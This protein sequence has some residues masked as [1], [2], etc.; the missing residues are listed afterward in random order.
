MHCMS[1]D[2]PPCHRLYHSVSS[3]SCSATRWGRV[4]SLWPLSMPTMTVSQW[5]ERWSL[6][7]TRWSKVGVLLFYW[8]LLTTKSVGYLKVS[9]FF[10]SLCKITNYGVKWT[11]YFSCFSLCSCL[12]LSVSDFITTLLPRMTNMDRIWIGLRIHPNNMEWID[13]SSVSYVHFNPLLLGMQRSVKV[14]VSWT[15]LYNVVDLCHST[16]KEMYV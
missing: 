7:L 3:Q 2:V 4:W 10:L 13:Q 11:D 6:Y 16:C 8:L 5:E 14:N 9:Q 1:H 15:S 12:C